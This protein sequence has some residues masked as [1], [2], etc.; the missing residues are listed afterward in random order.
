[1][2][3]ATNSKS[4]IYVEFVMCAE[5]GSE[6]Y[7]GINDLIPLS[8]SPFFSSSCFDLNE[9]NKKKRKKKKNGK[10]RKNKDHRTTLGKFVPPGSP[11]CLFCQ[12]HPTA[13]G[14]EGAGTTNIG[15]LW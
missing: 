10:P 2:A 6:K 8:L 5:D 9:L 13:T 11:R 7:E 14:A 12:S 4:L 15:L 3:V 1:M